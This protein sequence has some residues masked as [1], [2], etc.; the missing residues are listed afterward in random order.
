M[1]R[2]VAMLQGQSESKDAVLKP[3]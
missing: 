1:E 3:R 2:V